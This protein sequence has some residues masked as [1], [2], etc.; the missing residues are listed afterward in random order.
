MEDVGLTSLPSPLGHS[1]RDGAT[2]WS[3]VASSI[4][5]FRELRI[6][7]ESSDRVNKPSR[8]RGRK[9]QAIKCYCEET[10]A[11]LAEARNAIEAI[12]GENA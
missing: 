12:I 8:D 11:G 7:Q 10:G 5:P 2:R 9:I 6:P 3:S 4:F 1:N